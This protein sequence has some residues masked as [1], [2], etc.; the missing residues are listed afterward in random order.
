MVDMDTDVPTLVQ[1][2]DYVWQVRLP[3]GTILDGPR[4]SNVFTGLAAAENAA[5]AWWII[6]MTRQF[7]PKIER[8][9][10]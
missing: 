3:D 4:G 10:E 9:I 1:I 2:S 7:T 5:I 6:K 8:I